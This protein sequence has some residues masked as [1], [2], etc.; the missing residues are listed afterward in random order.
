MPITSRI[1]TV[2]ELFAFARSVEGEPLETLHR[3]RP[4]S[5]LVD[6]AKLSITPGSRK[7]R[8]TTRIR[9]AEVLKKLEKTGT[10]QPGQYQH[11]TYN[12]SYVLALVKL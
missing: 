3:P 5:V 11:L 12:A 2:E 6:G 4:F 9:V 1:P 8:A 7:P 10:F